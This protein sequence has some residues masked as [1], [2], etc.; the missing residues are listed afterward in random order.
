M[1]KVKTQ[2]KRNNAYSLN[3]HNNRIAY[4]GRDN[5]KFINRK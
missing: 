5:N 2:N 3:Y 4:S 1:Q